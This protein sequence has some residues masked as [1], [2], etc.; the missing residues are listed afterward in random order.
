MANVSRIN[1]DSKNDRISKITLILGG[2]AA[3]LIVVLFIFGLIG[4]ITTMFG[5]NQTSDLFSELQN[6]W[7]VI[8]YKVNIATSGIHADRLSVVNILDITIMAL[9]GIVFIGLYVKLGS[10]NKIWKI[11]AILLPFAG[12][13]VF[14][15]TATAGRSALMIAGIII[16]IVMLAS[17]QHAKIL[18]L[19]GI[20]AGILLFFA[21]DLGTTIYPGNPIVASCIVIGYFLWI[22]WFILVARKLLTNS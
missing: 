2:I 21:G 22:I 14:L 18:A 8:L 5:V 1:V 17:D 4:I 7:L 19:F 6:N 20:L 11:I 15:I 3:L 10:S 13:I 12:I 16:S 9:M